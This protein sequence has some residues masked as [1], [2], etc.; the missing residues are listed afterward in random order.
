MTLNE[1]N[2]SKI[3]QPFFKLYNTKP[4]VHQNNTGKIKLITGES[5]PPTTSKYTNASSDAHANPAAPSAR[6]RPEITYC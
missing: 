6:I 4:K 5:S 2:W 1:K 3:N